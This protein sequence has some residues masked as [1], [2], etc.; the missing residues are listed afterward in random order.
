MV[1]K[2]A[3][4]AARRRP[5]ASAGSSR[6][7]R[8]ATEK[9][10]Q[11][12]E[13]ST[14]ERRQT[15]G[16]PERRQARGGRPERKRQRSDVGAKTPIFVSFPGAGG[17]RS[18][19]TCL[20]EH[21]D[22]MYVNFARRPNLTT[23][24]RAAPFLQE[25]CAA[26][27]KAVAEYGPSRPL[28]LVGH[29]FGSRAIAHLLADDEQ[30]STLPASFAGAIFFGYPLLHPTQHRETVLQKIPRCVPALLISGTRDSFMGNFKLLEDALVVPGLHARSAGPEVGLVSS[31]LLPRLFVSKVQDGDH[32]LA[33]PK[34]AE[35]RTNH[36]VHA[37]LS[38]FLCHRLRPNAAMKANHS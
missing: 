17:G 8:L 3:A 30:R 13:R 32:S 10:R 34:K 18:R 23:P 11:A 4:A 37:A 12:S 25:I 35:E 26:A 19:H 29:S 38:E 28:L 9:S 15:R 22:M 16:R 33:C 31:K 1:A 7:L 2:Q 24:E 14:E 5:A 27:S 6:A 21:G 36:C 20:E